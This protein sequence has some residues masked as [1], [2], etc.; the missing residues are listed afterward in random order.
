MGEPVNSVPAG[1]YPDPQGLADERYFD[2]NSWTNETRAASPLKQKD[3]GIA[4]SSSTLGAG[5]IQAVVLELQKQTRHLSAIR[6]LLFG[7][8]VFLVVIPL[9]LGVFLAS[10]A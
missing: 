1:W 8:Y 5:D 2:G 10:Q 3:S 9:L 6:W 4:A 7:L